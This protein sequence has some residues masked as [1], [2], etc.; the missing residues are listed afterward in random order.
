MRRRRVRALIVVCTTLV[1]FAAVA[2]LAQ[3][4]ANKERVTS[5]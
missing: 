1:A 5:M 4:L 2:A 3:L